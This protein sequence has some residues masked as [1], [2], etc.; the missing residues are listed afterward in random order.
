MT[1]R[2]CRLRS[3]LQRLLCVVNAYGV[4]GR[5]ATN[6]SADQ[7]EFELASGS[8]SK[9]I[10]LAAPRMVRGHQRPYDVFKLGLI[11]PAYFMSVGGFQYSQS[12]CQHLL[13]FLLRYYDELPATEASSQEPSN[14]F[15]MRFQNTN[16][17]YCRGGYEEIEGDFETVSLETFEY[18]VSPSPFLDAKTLRP[19]EFTPFQ[20]DGQ[21]RP[22]PRFEHASPRVSVIIP[23]YGSPRYT[24][25]I[26]NEVEALLPEL[27]ALNGRVII[28]VDGHDHPLQTSLHLNLLKGIDVETVEVHSH[29]KNIGF[30][31][32][33]NFL[34]EK[35]SDDE[36]VVLLTTDVKMQPGS[37][38]RVIAPLVSNDDIALSTPFAVGGENLEAPESDVLHWRDLDTILSNVETSYPDAETNV[39]YMLAIDRRKYPAAELFDEF[40]ENGYG[41]DSDLYYR[42]VNLGFRGVVADNCCVFHEHGASFDLTSMRSELRSENFRRFMGRWGQVHSERHPKAAARLDMLKSERGRLASALVQSLPM[43][44]IVFLLPTNLRTIGGVAAVFDLVEALCDLGVSAAVICRQT[45]FDESGFAS[46]SISYDNVARRDIVLANATVLI[47]TSSDTVEPVQELAR[48][49]ELKTG[50]FIQGPEFSFSDGQFLSSVVTGYLGFDAIFVVSRFLEEVVK[51]H[52]DKPISLIPYGPRL[53]KYYNLGIS[54]EPK[55]IA[56]QLNGNTNKG[57][58]FVAGVVASLVPKGY[59]IYSF[60]DDALRSKRKNFCTHLGFLT[61]AEKIR[62]FNRVEF[63]LDASNYEGLGLLLIESI[64]CGAIPVYRHNGGTSEILKTAGC[65]IEIGDYAAIGKID[66]Q[67]SE[68]RRNANFETEREFCK[69]S[70]EGHTLE[71]AAEAMLEWYNAQC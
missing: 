25:D 66:Q 54:R 21:N 15:C 34:Y 65:G 55:S 70:V 20:L 11:M 6:A 69:K 40:F 5:S 62:L 8:S 10:M 41:D 16:V 61:T 31:R 9:Y 22:L 28:S 46:R 50:Y 60:G 29:E 49:H 71:A 12:L 24:L 26:R 36:I 1:A 35:T 39:G 59:R 63:Y 53:E 4:Q 23:V 57:A 64:R 43:P 32:N 27:K 68:F 44:K 13:E 51:D 2:L 47:A 19:I 52:V 38:S 3:G 33:V 30:I 58:A 42:C 67:L 56:V 37:L 17:L 48:Q 14:L 18:I 7:A 45:P